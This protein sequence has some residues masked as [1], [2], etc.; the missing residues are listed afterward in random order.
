MRLA[1]ITSHPI[2]YNAP[3]FRQ[4]SLYNGHEIKVF[5]TWGER[6]LKDKF[7]PGFNK[8]IEWDVLLLEGYEYEF[9][10]NI[11][12]EPG[13]H[14]FTG[15]NNP[16]LIERIKQWKAEAIIV[17]GWAFKSHFKVMKYFKGK[18]P[19]LFRGDSTLLDNNPGI[20]SIARKIAL[21]YVYHYADKA[22]FVGKAN[23]NYFQAHGFSD[24]NLVFVPHAVDNNR[25]VPNAKNISGGKAMREQ[26]N[27]PP[28]AIVFLFAGKLE[29]KKAP[30]LLASAFISANL[31]KSHLVITGNGKLEA[32]IKECYS[33]VKNIHFLDFQNQSLMPGLYQIGDVFVLPSSG[34]GET[35]GLAINE[36]MAAGLAIICSDKCGAAADLVKTGVNGYIFKAGNANELATMMKTLTR[37]TIENMGKESQGIIKDWS[38]E[39]ASEAIR[40]L[41]DKR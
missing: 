14:H 6:V 21:R 5:Y 9:L 34:P 25:F 36:A 27:I 19:I 39:K 33:E 7:D 17:Y 2:Q 41:L 40:N 23:K 12:K 28:D 20:K 31:P 3:L 30:S 8:K 24:K 37:E 15:I 4:L 38:V 35:W 13:S 26:F 1:I 11:S 16:D 22:L 32:Q 18:I 10:E 29:E